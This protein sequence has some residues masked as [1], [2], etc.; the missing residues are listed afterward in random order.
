MSSQVPGPPPSEPNP[1]GVPSPLPPAPGQAAPAPQYGAP[2]PQYGGGGYGGPGGY[3]QPTPPSGGGGGGKTGLIIA[4]VLA[5]VLLIGGAAA[6]LIIVLTGGDDSD[7]DDDTDKKDDDTSQTDT[8]YETAVEDYFTAYD[9]GDCDTILDLYPDQFADVE[10]CEDEYPYTDPDDVEIEIGSLE[11]T[12]V[13]DEADPTE[14]TVEVSFTE[15][16]LDGDT[17]DDYTVEFTLE[18]DGDDWIITA[19][20]SV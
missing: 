2:A 14:A 13:D 11:T 20:D 8:G 4:I 15:V 17:E 10:E 1:Q 3:Q 19:Y 9:D 7:K 6:A 12:D 5:V 16:D 18:K